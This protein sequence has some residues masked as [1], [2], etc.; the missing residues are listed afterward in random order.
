MAVVNITEAEFG[1]VAHAAHHAKRD[2]DDEGAA[3]LDKLARKMNAALSNAKY[4][5]TRFAVGSG[6]KLTWKDVP[7]V[8][9]EI[10]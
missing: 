9:V 10:V 3:A 6:N 1:F 4:A 8:F 5:T 2:G 7:S